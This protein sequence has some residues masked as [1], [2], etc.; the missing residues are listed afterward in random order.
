MGGWGNLHFLTAMD[1]YDT[2]LRRGTFLCFFLLFYSTSVS[3]GDPFN[4]VV[5]IIG[6]GMGM[7]F[8]SMYLWVRID[9]A[10]VHAYLGGELGIYLGFG[11]AK[12]KG[13]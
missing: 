2:T 11:W 5:V 10:L 1:G 12:D 4:R 13:H 7:H 8:A 9:T 6:S 3:S